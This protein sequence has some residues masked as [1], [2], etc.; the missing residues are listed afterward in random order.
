[1][2]KLVVKNRANAVI[3]YRLRNAIEKG[4]LRNVIEQWPNMDNL[5]SKGSCQKHPEGWCAEF[6]GGQSILIM[7]WGDNS[8]SLG[9]GGR[10]VIHFSQAIL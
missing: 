4:R 6:G 10:G 8:V 5:V 9:L 7:G 1:M 3:T 2:L